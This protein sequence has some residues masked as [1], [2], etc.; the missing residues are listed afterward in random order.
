M[1]IINNKLYT[2][3][4]KCSISK[5]KTILELLREHNSNTITNMAA[6]NAAC[7]N[8]INYTKEDLKQTSKWKKYIKKIHDLIIE[9]FPN[10]CLIKKTNNAYLYQSNTL[11]QNIAFEC[12][13]E[14]NPERQKCTCII[15]NNGE[16]SFHK[17]KKTPK[18]LYKEMT[19]YID[20]KNAIDNSASVPLVF[21]NGHHLSF[22]SNNAKE[23]TSF[24][25]ID[26]F[27]ST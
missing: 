27:E 8:P 16:K 23:L 11:K 3:R 7:N 26:N 25:L 24:N 22:I 17:T 19:D 15:Y 2:Q 1:D 6:I 9:E 4:D 13:F 21:P 12:R 10:M 5:N 20:Y 18:R 14:G